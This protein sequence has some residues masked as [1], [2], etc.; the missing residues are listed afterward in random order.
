MQSGHQRSPHPPARIV[1]PDKQEAVTEPQID[2]KWG[3]DKMGRFTAKASAARMNH[4]RI[5]SVPKSEAGKS[6]ADS[7]VNIFEIEEV[8]LVQRNQRFGAGSSQI[9]GSA[10]RG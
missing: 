7:P 6:R 8:P 2:C 3:S 9:Q 1:S 4:N 10:R 5:V